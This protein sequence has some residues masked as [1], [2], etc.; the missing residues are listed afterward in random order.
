MLHEPFS[1]VKVL[2]ISDIHQ[3]TYIVCAHIYDGYVHDINS[4]N[5]KRILFSI[6]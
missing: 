3:Y 5:A 1:R 6:A 2:V 4:I